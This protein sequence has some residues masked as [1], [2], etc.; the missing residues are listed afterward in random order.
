ME[1][2]TDT[3]WQTTTR[4]WECT[5]RVI[6]NLMKKRNKVKPLNRKKIGLKFKWLM[7]KVNITQITTRVG[8]LISRTNNEPNKDHK[9]KLRKNVKGG[10]TTLRDR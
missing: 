6:S 10:E 4:C 9:G 8:C 5:S 7:K 2:Y 3:T 1:A